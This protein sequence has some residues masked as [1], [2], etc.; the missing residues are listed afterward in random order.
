MRI[1]QFAA[2]SS[3]LTI[4]LAVS[5]AAAP[6]AAQTVGPMMQHYQLTVPIDATGMPPEVRSVGAMCVLQTGLARGRN[7]SVTSGNAAGTDVPVAS[8]TAHGEV[9]INLQAT[10][11]PAAAYQC[12]ISFFVVTAS[13]T[14]YVNTLT[15][16]HATVPHTGAD[17]VTGYLT[18]P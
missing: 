2:L 17:V 8:G 12:F 14:G 16:P 4:G 15:I 18:T 5:A 13:Y 10:I 9:T 7:A 6:A 1:R 3:L 11:G